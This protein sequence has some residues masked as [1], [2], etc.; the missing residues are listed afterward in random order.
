MPLNVSGMIFQ[1]GRRSGAVAR[2]TIQTAS[3]ITGTTS[4][5]AGNFRLAVT[6]AG[7]AMTR[8]AAT[9]PTKVQSMCRPRG[10]SFTIGEWRCCWIEAGMP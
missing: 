7:I 2:M 6:L 5:T 4:S 3:P 8:I 1:S 10:A 9:M